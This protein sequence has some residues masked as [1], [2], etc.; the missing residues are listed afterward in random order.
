MCAKKKVPEF[1]AENML[2][3][4]ILLWICHGPRKEK[5]VSATVV[6]FPKLFMFSRYLAVNYDINVLNAP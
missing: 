3:C 5:H 6:M 1:A 2:L 4:T